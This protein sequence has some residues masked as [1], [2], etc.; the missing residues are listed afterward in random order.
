[1][2]VKIT[3]SGRKGRFYIPTRPKI[4]LD[5]DEQEL[6]LLKNVAKDWQFVDNDSLIENTK[7]SPPFIWTKEGE[8]IPFA[9]YLEFLKRYNEAAEPAFGEGGGTSR[10]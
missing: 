7:K 6:A 3:P 4:D 8:E 10:V 2:E 9:R 1:M 5:L